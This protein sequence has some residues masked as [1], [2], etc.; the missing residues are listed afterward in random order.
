MYSRMTP[1][2]LPVIALLDVYFNMFGVPSRWKIVHRPGSQLLHTGWSKCHMAVQGRYARC[3][4]VMVS[5]AL[6][7]R[8]VVLMTLRSSNTFNDERRVSHKNIPMTAELRVT[9]CIVNCK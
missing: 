7:T 6:I 1:A 4:I 3:F 5:L 8:W 9:S 2:P